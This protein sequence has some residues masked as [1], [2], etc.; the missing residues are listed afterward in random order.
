MAIT[1]MPTR[2]K[3]G[4]SSHDRLGMRLMMTPFHRILVPTDFSEPSHAALDLAIEMAQR[5]DAE[6]ELFHA[7][8]LPAYI[9]PDGVVPISPGIIADLDRTTRAELDRLAMR[10]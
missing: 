2:S 8:E 1:K 4:G 3:T 7:Q 5:F 10:V 9:F 6:L